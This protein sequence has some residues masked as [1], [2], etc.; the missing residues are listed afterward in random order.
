MKKI[1]ILFITIVLLLSGCT[2]KLNDIKDDKLNIVTTIF[3]IYDFVRAIG[4]DLVEIKLL[5]DPGTEV[6]SY[7]PSPSD[8]TAIYDADLFF[9]IGGESDKWVETILS[10][11]DVDA[12][13]LMESVC[14]LAE[15]HHDEIDEHIWTSPENA[16]LMLN[17]ILESISIKDKKN[18]KTYESNYEEYSDEIK[19]LDNK[20]KEIVD[21]SDNKFILVADRFP[22]EYF[23]NYYGIKYDAAF[24]GCAISTDISI[25]TMNRLVKVINDKNIDS[26]FCVEMS[27]KNIA[28]ALRE[29]LGVKIFELH[30]AHNVSKSDFLNNV[31]YVDIMKRNLK[32]LERG[33]N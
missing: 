2:P 33:I 6:H 29:E 15:A 16:F 28:N 7:D 27:N 32:S 31:T 26:V 19:E 12:I 4:G 8:I 17:K 3:P 22:F 5:V 25:K 13:R 20:F 30:S 18:S 9:Y 24:D 14:V 21:K 1:V 23:T 10:D 11:T